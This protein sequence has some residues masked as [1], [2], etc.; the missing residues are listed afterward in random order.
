MPRGD[1]VRSGYQRERNV[2]EGLV[3]VN[4][5]PEVANLMSDQEKPHRHYRQFRQKMHETTDTG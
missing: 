5:F 1:D 4:S 3:G 2:K